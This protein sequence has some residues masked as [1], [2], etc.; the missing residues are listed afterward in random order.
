MFG[1]HGAQSIE[2]ASYDRERERVSVCVCVSGRA[3]VF[4][5]P[6]DAL[7]A[8][9]RDFKVSGAYW[10]IIALLPVLAAVNRVASRA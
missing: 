2:A 9:C 1:V 7:L 5:F 6:F 3:S 10:R 4:G 8:H